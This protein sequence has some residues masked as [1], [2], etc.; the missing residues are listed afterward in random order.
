M[1]DN[2]QGDNNALVRSIKALLELDA[3]GALVPHGIGGH[4]RGLLSAAASRLGQP[5][6]P[7]HTLGGSRE[8]FTRVFNMG[9]NSVQFRPADD[10]LWD[11]TLRD[12]DHYHDMADKLAEAIAEHFKAEIGEHSNMNCPWQSAL[13]VIENAAQP[14][15]PGY[16]AEIGLAGQAYLNT[17][18]GAHPLPTQFRWA[19]LWMD[20]CKAAAPTP[21]AD[22]QAQQDADKV[23]AEPVGVVCRRTSPVAGLNGS[24]FYEGVEWLKA[25]P[26][27]GTKLYAARAQ[28]GDT[29]GR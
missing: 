3:K 6:Q 23:D 1:T 13:E 26:P 9:R 12:R 10:E 16:T 15:V 25:P 2:F 14:S 28:Q 27:L 22:G 4:T 17:F 8:E 21:P 11:K 24:V 18:K 5:A 29:H 20:M 19:D 7:A